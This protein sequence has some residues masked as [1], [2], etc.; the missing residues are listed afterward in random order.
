MTNGRKT[1]TSP[2]AR[3]QGTLIIHQRRKLYDGAPTRALSSLAFLNTITLAEDYW[4]KITTADVHYS[5]THA[6]VGDP[7]EEKRPR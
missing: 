3:K 7:A 2:V 5:F 4:P 1:T 6:H